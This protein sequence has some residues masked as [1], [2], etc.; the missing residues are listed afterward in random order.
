[1]WTGFDRKIAPLVCIEFA[2]HTLQIAFINYPT[3][4]YISL[5]FQ[6]RS[7]FF[8]HR[9]GFFR[10]AIHVMHS[11]VIFIPP[12]FAPMFRSSLSKVIIILA[13]FTI[14]GWVRWSKYMRLYECPGEARNGCGR[15]TMPV[16]EGNTI[17][18]GA[19][20]ELW[21]L[22]RSGEKEV[23]IHVPLHIS[24]I[25]STLS[26]FS[27]G[28]FYMY[29]SQICYVLSLSSCEGEANIVTFNLALFSLFECTFIMCASQM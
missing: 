20:F 27:L 8:F 15:P 9:L 26:S 4:N 16:V 29:I 13:S 23:T 19:H 11:K 6:K 24:Q 18:C 25:K 21:R 22:N 10:T 1:M 17:Q 12:F 7:L 14:K 2:T 28:L 3:L 5:A